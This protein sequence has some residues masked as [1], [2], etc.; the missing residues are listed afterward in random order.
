M[1]PGRFEGDCVEPHAA[2]VRAS[3]NLD[4]EAA[5]GAS[6]QRLGGAR[7]LIAAPVRGL[8]AVD[9]AAGDAQVFGKDP[10]PS[11]EGHR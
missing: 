11:L 10:D 2:T 7:T 4:P 9:P 1:T 3:L 5:V 6:S 8:V